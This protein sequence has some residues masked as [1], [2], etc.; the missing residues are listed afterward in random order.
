MESEHTL[1]ESNFGD[2]KSSRAVINRGDFLDS[3]CSVSIAFKLP[4]LSTQVLTAIYISIK[5]QTRLKMS[6]EADISGIDKYVLM[7]KLWYGVKWSGRREAPFY[8]EAEAREIFD[9]HN[10]NLGTWQVEVCG[11]F[12]LIDLSEDTVNHASYD[13]RNGTG[14]FNRILE[15]IR[16]SQQPQGNITQPSATAQSTS[17]PLPDAQADEENSASLEDH[18]AWGRLAKKVHERRGRQ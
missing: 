1:S 14:A 7:R 4:S 17:G 5:H 12:L 2:S 16:T 6:K 8:D 3:F 9:K 13:L 18:S 11:K 10:G 15:K